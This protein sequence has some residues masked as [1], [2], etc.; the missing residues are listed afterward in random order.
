MVSMFALQTVDF[1]KTGIIIL[2]ECFFSIISLFLT[3]LSDL[4][5]KIQYFANNS[6]ESTKL[7]F[8]WE[9]LG[10]LIMLFSANTI[11]SDF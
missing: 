10:F 1:I 4:N 2:C 7:L 9:L 11:H 5:I 8:G 6:L 3:R